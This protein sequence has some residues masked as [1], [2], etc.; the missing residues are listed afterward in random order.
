MNKDLKKTQP[1]AIII[2]GPTGIGKTS[3]AIELAKLFKGEIVGADSMQIYRHMDIGTAKPNPAERSVIRHH[4]VDIIDPDEPFDAETYATQALSIVM[5]LQKQEVLPFVVGGTGL[6]IKSL[7]YG[8]FDTRPADQEI[9]IRLKQEAEKEGGAVLYERLKK[10]DPV[11][12]G[13]IHINDTYRIV[14]A[15]EVYEASGA[16]IS[17]FQRRH[18]FQ[19]SRLTPLKFGLYMEREQLYDRIDERVEMMI[20]AG[21]LDEVKH[22]R[23]VGY[24]SELKSMQSLG[25]RHM[26]DFLDGRMDWPETIRTLKRDTR[27]YAKRQMTWFKADR[28]VVWVDPVV[29]KDVENRT[30][31]FLSDQ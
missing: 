9:R 4:M 20:H 17:D 15:L 12:A 8:L 23:D 13:K 6:Y 29:S 11:T 14:R 30:R 1:T 2:C 3:F 22:L 7:L 10:V 5:A 25:Y 16:P 31:N 19:K 28:E 18:G 27:R 21:I 26:H 24:G